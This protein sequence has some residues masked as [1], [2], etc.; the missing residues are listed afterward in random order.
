M[1]ANIPGPFILQPIDGNS[2]RLLL[3]ESVPSSIAARTFNALAW[4]PMHF[5]ME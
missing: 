4:D 3:R 5:I 1:I 2:A